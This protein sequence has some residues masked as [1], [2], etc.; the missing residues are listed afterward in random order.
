MKDLLY[1]IRF[2]LKLFTAGTAIIGAILLFAGLVAM[3]GLHAGWLNTA[4]FFTL[5]L[6]TWFLVEDKCKF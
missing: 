6:G 3:F 1:W 2:W 5:A 4:I